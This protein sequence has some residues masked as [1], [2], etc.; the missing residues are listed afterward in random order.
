MSQNN[1]TP[2]GAIVLFLVFGLPLAYAVFYFLGM[3]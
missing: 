1:I 2:G 3:R